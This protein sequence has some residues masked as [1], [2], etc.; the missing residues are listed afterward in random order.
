MSCNC[1]KA[2]NIEDVYNHLNGNELQKPI[3]GYKFVKKIE[4]FLNQSIIC[5]LMLISI[6]LIIIDILL[7]IILTFKMQSTIIKLFV[8]HIKK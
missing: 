6:P 5:F 4:T 8:K 3:R 2:K 1:K 7:N